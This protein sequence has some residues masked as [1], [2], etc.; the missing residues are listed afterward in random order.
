M[1]ARPGSWSARR[2][3]RQS[4]A[5]EVARAAE[6]LARKLTAGRARVREAQRVSKAAAAA[7]PLNHPFRAITARIL[8]ARANS[9]RRGGV[10]A[11][12]LPQCRASRPERLRALSS[13]PR[14]PITVRCS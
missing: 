9:C 2:A 14:A 3:A 12:A 6:E 10:T 5:V 4:A 8:N 1:T 11:T 7:D 13:A